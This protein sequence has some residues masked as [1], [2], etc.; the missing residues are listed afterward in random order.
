MGMVPLVWELCFRTSPNLKSSEVVGKTR[1]YEGDLPVGEYRLSCGVAKISD[2]S[3]GDSY[4]FSLTVG[5]D[6]HTK[7]IMLQFSVPVLV[8]EQHFIPS[9]VSI[10]KLTVCKRGSI[11]MY[12][13]LRLKLYV[14]AHF[15]FGDNETYRRDRFYWNLWYWQGLGVTFVIN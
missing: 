4:S 5:K 12:V 11:C 8:Y 3:H 2:R 13:R 7:F 9:I 10:Y 15:I 14:R 6:A 1:E